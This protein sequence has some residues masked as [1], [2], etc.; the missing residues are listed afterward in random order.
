MWIHYRVSALGCV[1]SADKRVP[2]MLVIQHDIV[3]LGNKKE[4]TRSL[5]KDEA[6]AIYSVKRRW[7]KLRPQLADIQA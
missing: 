5:S 3:P 2:L 1:V 7:P 4:Y 6:K